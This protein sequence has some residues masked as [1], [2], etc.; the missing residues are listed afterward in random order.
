MRLCKMLST[1]VGLIWLLTYTFHSVLKFLFR[2]SGSQ[3][4]SL[5]AMSKLLSSSNST[6]LPCVGVGL[7]LLTPQASAAGPALPGHVCCGWASLSEKWE[8][9]NPSFCFLGM[10]PSIF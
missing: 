7:A 1:N 3:R 8:E 6:W 4:A 5:S 9:S 2:M 10:L